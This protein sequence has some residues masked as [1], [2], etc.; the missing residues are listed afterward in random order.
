MNGN[1]KGKK[2][3]KPVLS[4]WIFLKLKWHLEGKWLR[5]IYSFSLVYKELKHMETFIHIVKIY[6]YLTKG[7]VELTQ[8]SFP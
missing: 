3:K 1:L 6:T 8:S 7:T 2:K 5:V 4:S